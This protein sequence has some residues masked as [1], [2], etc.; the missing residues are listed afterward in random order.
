MSAYWPGRKVL[1]TGGSGFVGRVVVHK[2]KERG[3][4]VVAPSHAEA[5]LTHAAIADQLFADL[6]VGNDSIAA[7]GALAFANQVQS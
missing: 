7:S 2:L 4:D 1:V 3:A 5:D 6:G